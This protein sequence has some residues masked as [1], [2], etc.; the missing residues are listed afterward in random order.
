MCRILALPLRENINHQTR[1]NPMAPE[2]INAIIDAH[3]EAQPE[4]FRTVGDSLVGMFRNLFPEA[5]FSV[6]P[7]KD[8]SYFALHFGVSADIADQFLSIIISTSG[9]SLR[10]NPADALE[11]DRELTVKDEEG[12]AAYYR[13][14]DDTFDPAYFHFLAKQAQTKTLTQQVGKPADSKI[15]YFIYEA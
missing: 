3:W 6:N 1:F 5:I 13:V 14:S 9:V 7:V 10:L 11:D 4:E 8:N 2:N 15:S 12:T